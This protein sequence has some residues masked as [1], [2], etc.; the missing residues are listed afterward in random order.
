[1][2][3]QPKIVSLVQTL[4]SLKQ[5]EKLVKEQIK[6]AT[7]DLYM[8]MSKVGTDKVGTNDIGSATAVYKTEILISPQGLERIQPI[9]NELFAIKK[10]LE[11]K[12][13]EREEVAKTLLME[14]LAK[15]DKV[16]SFIKYTAPKVKESAVEQK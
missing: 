15:E 9:D 5:Q 3:K 1:M 8:A 16:F 14:G 10:T 2:A 12:Q 4:G 7:V 6:Q 13:E 11:S